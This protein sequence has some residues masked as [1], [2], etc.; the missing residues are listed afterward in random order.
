M[1]S[2]NLI[3]KYTRDT[4]QKQGRFLFLYYLFFV[5]L[6]LTLNNKN[7]GDYMT[8]TPAKVLIRYVKRGNYLGIN[9]LK[10]CFRNGGFAVRDRKGQTELFTY[11][12]Q[13]AYN[14]LMLIPD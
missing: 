12:F 14:Y 9:G 6:F 3:L 1:A 8:A 11:N 10:L 4:G 7:I 5:Y 2:L 13:E